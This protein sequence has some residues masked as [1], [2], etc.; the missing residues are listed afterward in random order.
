MQRHFTLGLFALSAC[1]TA[2][3]PLELVDARAA[4]GKAEQ[5]PAKKYKPDELHEAKVSLDAAE[6][7]F[8][9]DADGNKAK[10][11]AY[12]A[13]RR[14]QLA[15]VDGAAAQAGDATAQANSQYTKAA[16]AGLQRAQ[17]ELTQTREQLAA[18]G[19]Q[20]ATETQAR[21]EADQ[22]AKD[23]LAR[24]DDAMLK[25]SV[26]VKKDDRGTVIT[27]PGSVLFSSGKSA[28]LS[29]AES[30][31]G[32]VADAL[33]DQ[34]DRQITVDGFTDSRGSEETNKVLSDRRAQSVRDFL[35]GHGI[36]QDR[37][38]AVGLGP[39]QPVA[40]NSTAE[41]RADNRR[42]EIIVKAGEPR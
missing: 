37:V 29:S 39:S 6:G 33:K 31:L 36:P 32:Q 9:R 41:G 21:Q 24:L 19:Q 42:V 8:H 4:Y 23:A 25:L 17:G 26:P 16:T 34:P 22:R 2:N 1:A 10:T 27:F 15:E 7:E 12:V 18:Q 30:K 5:G 14:A 35:V 38:S 13:Q 11:L 28:L 40:D 3:P 20:L